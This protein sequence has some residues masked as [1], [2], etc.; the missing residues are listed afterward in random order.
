[1]IIIGHRGAAGIEAENTV[2]SIEAAVREGVDMIEFDLRVTKDGHL[3]IF[4]DHNLLRI[5]GVNKNV[6]EMTLREIQVSTTR[7]GHPIPT[8]VEGLEAAAHIPVLLDCKGKGWAQALHK[9]LENYNGPTPAVTAI[10]TNEMFKF[11]QLHPE[12]KTYVSELTRPFEG[13]YKARLLGFTGISLNFWVMNPL[14]YY[15]ARRN[16]L[17]LLIFTINHKFLARFM[18]LLYPSAAIITN[19]P[20]KLAPLARRRKKQGGRTS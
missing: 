2:P 8:V 1:M 14:A 19:V 4:H 13:I 9:K 12:I 3:V 15:Y 10:D 11:R 17:E 5:S 18:H 16:N 6:S 20:H 7:S